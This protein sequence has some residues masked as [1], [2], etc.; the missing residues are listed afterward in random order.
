[1]KI[2]FA[3]T[4]TL[5]LTSGVLFISCSG[6]NHEGELKK[7]KPVHVTVASATTQSDNTI[8]A[9]GQIESKETAIIS[10]RMMGFITNIKVKAGDKVEKGQLLVTINNAD[11]LAKRAQAVA[12]VSEAEAALKDAQKD[13][14]RFV[15][16]YEQNSAS[17]KEFE[18]ATLR[19]NSIQAKTEA[20]KQMQREAEAML[21]YA[22]LTAPFSGVIT[23][24]NIDA[25]S[26]ANPGVPILIMEQTGNYQVIASISESDIANVKEGNKVLVTIK[27]TGRI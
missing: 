22:N 17:Q 23:Q 6:N 5:L 13:Y 14:E 19:F 26:M 4:A 10:T 15:Q 27:S 2:Q 9:S 25:G 24:K 16:L 21:T 12:M 1:M 7:E 11:I 8:Q 18:N 3:L 20:A